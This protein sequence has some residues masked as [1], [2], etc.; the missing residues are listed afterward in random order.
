VIAGAGIGIL[1][2]LA[3]KYYFDQRKIELTRK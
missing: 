1:F 2:T 3:I